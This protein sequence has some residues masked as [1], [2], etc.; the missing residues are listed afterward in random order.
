MINL[1]NGNCLE[2][3]KELPDN[4]VTLLLTDPP[5]GTTHAKWDSHL[6]WDKL[7]IEI[8]RVLK[9]EGIAAIFAAQ[10]FTSDLIYSQRQYFKYTWIWMKEQ[11]TG[12]LNAKRRP[13]MQTEDICIFYKKFGL[14]NPQMREGKQISYGGDVVKSELYSNGNDINR[15]KVDTNKRYPTNILKYNRPLKKGL[16]IH[17]TQ[18]PVGLLEELILTYT[19]KN[20][21]VLDICTGS[22]STAVASI[23]NDRKFI[24][25]ELNNEMFNKSKIWIDKQLQEIKNV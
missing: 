2:L 3:I 25:F 18:K 24:G 21:V 23:K 16:R 14:Y 4:S 8:W 7:W 10:P 17:S 22:G 11:G 6:D 20:E 13:M 9:P 19:Q 1:L 5:Y 15:P 12:Q